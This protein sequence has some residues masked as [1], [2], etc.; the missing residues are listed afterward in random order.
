MIMPPPWSPN[1]TRRLRCRAQMG[2][3]SMP[4]VQTILLRFIADCQY[5]EVTR[6]A[7][8]RGG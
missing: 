2:L 3:A 4:A 6:V 8:I 7:L 1:A 5:R